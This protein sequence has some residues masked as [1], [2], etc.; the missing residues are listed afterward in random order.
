MTTLVLGASEDISR[1]SNKAVRLLRTY[2][3]DVLAIGK[4]KGTIGDV[5]IE[6]AFPLSEKIDTITLYLNPIHQSIYY[7]DI[8]SSKPRRIIFNPGAENNELKKLAEAN[9]IQTEEACTL[10]LLNTN[11]Y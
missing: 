1:Y 10:V 9:N 11:Q 8:I 7:Q 4:Q 3:H 5:T 6:T 2:N